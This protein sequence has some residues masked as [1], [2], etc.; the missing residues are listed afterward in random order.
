MKRK[1]TTPSYRIRPSKRRKYNPKIQI[2]LPKLCQ[3]IENIKLICRV[4]RK[5]KKKYVVL[6]HSTFIRI[7]NNL[8]ECL[9]D[10]DDLIQFKLPKKI[11]KI[12]SRS[13]QE[14][15]LK[16]SIRK[17]ER[18][19][20]RPFNQNLINIIQEFDVKNRP[21]NPKRSK[22]NTRTKIQQS[23]NDYIRFKIEKMESYIPKLEEIQNHITRQLDLFIY[24]FDNIKPINLENIQYSKND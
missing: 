13:I 1:R 23:T 17:R 19:K 3:S 12:I 2:Y 14:F 15:K 9:T 4:A 22:Y 20:I 8:S 21:F 5:K 7:R 10:I 18:R 11:T 6:K 16:D 24:V